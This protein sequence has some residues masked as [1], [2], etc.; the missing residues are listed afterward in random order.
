MLLNFNL[1]RD[2]KDFK[3]YVHLTIVDYVNIT[4]QQMY[5]KVKAPVKN[6]KKKN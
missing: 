4:Q 1:K 6:K 5:S 3:V 2:A